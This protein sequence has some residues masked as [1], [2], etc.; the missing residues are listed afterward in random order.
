MALWTV[1]A[2]YTFY[3][4]GVFYTSANSNAN[5]ASNFQLI[6]RTLGGVF[7]QQSSARTAGNGSFVLNL[8]TPIAF[9][10]KTDIEIRAI[11]SA[12]SSN[13][14]AEFEGIYI[15]NPD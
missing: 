15:K 3:L 5:S 9:A 10:E 4:T 13:V 6:Q 14:S 12:A 2:N 7:R 8:H 1:P 11:A